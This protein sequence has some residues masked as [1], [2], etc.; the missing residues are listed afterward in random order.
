[1]SATLSDRGRMSN[2]DRKFPL[3]ILWDMKTL[4]SIKVDKDIKTGA[5]KVARDLR[6]PL[7]TI[8]NAQLRDLIRTRTVSISSLPRM[9][10]YLEEASRRAEEDYRRGVN[11]SPTFENVEDAV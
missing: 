11:I 4:I 10:P 2:L 1:M 3:Y 6:L 7:S 8:V 9:T 5:Q